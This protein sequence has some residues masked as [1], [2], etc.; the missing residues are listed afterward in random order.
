MEPNSPGGKCGAQ[1]A[2]REMAAMLPS[3]WV[4]LDDG[5]CNGPRSF[6][7]CYHGSGYTEYVWF[8]ELIRGGAE[9]CERKTY[10][11]YEG[12]SCCGREVTSHELVL[13]L[14]AC[15]MNVDD[16]VFN[17]VV[18]KPYVVRVVL[19]DVRTKECRTFV[20]KS[21]VKTFPQQNSTSNVDEWACSYVGLWSSASRGINAP[22]VVSWASLHERAEAFPVFDLLSPLKRSIWN[23]MKEKHE[24]DA[25]PWS[26]MR[27]VV[28][29]FQRLLSSS[30]EQRLQQIEIHLQQKL[31]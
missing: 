3:C 13:Y 18:L 14:A 29:S 4:L 5:V 25:E 26:V 6:D 1:L 10:R 12:E 28:W 20:L 11:P 21:R 15:N 2:W 16:I 23:L 30:P 8:S 24:R 31:N 27:K 19:Y 22:E 17:A 9:G 7:N